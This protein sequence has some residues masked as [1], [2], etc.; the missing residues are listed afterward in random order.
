MTFLY[1]IYLCYY[2]L[3]YYLP[4]MTKTCVHITHGVENVIVKLFKKYIYILETK[5]PLITAK[6]PGFVG[7]D[8]SCL[9]ILYR[10][11]SCGAWTKC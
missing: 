9:D 2:M 5:R 11:I 6:C 8:I 7:M 10:D 1:V 4:Q 3:F